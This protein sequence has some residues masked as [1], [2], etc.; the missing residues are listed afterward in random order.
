MKIDCYMQRHRPCFETYKTDGFYFTIGLDK[1]YPCYRKHVAGVYI[2]FGHRVMQL[3]W[4]F[5][6]AQVSSDSRFE[7]LKSKIVAELTKQKK[8]KKA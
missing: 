1:A 4:G 7:D 6:I 5:H 3:L 8:R 2:I